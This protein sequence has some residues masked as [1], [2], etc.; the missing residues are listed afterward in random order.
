M[1]I[2]RIVPLAAVAVIAAGAF[3][4]ATA[5]PAKDKPFTKSYEM[6]L[7]PANCLPEAGDYGTHLES[8][9]VKGPGTLTATIKGFEGDWDLGIRNSDDAELAAGGGST[10]GEPA[11]GPS[12][13]LIYKIKKPGKYT[14]ASCNFAGTLDATGSY[15]FK[16]AK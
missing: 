15:T 11:V 6:H 13:I 16:P 5:A 10:T 12:E 2:R 9:T 8:F 7:Y 4:P 1:Q 3:V 14:I